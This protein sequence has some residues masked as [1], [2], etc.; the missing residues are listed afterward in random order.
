[1][2]TRNRK[3]PLDAEWRS[4][5]QTGVLLNRLNANAVGAEILTPG[6]IKSAEILL[7]KVLPDLKAI[8]VSGPDGGPVRH[9]VEI[10]FVRP[11]ETDADANP[12]A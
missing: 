10:V 2:A 1:M 8:E 12:D 7:K 4:R 3:Q 5:I 6:Q 11:D 9:S